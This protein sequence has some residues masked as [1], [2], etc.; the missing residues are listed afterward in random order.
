LVIHLQDYK[1][2]KQMYKNAQKN[3]VND[4]KII[5]ERTL[6]KIEPNIEAKYALLSK[7]SGIFDVN[8]FMK[9]LFTLCKKNGVK[10]I[11]NKKILHGYF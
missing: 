4:V 6:K 1:L 10:F 9:K 8:D 2:I 7:S 11:Y 3:E 5:T